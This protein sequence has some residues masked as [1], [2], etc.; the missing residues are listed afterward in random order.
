MTN[1]EMKEITDRLDK[2]TYKLGQIQAKLNSIEAGH[3]EPKE[4]PRKPRLKDIH[5]EKGYYADFPTSEEDDPDFK[6]KF[7]KLVRGLDE[8]S[9]K[10]ITQIIQRL[11]ILKESTDDFLPEFSDD[12]MRRLEFVEN[13]FYPEILR[14]CEG[15]YSYNG[16]VLPVPTFEPSVFLDKCGLNEISAPEEIVHRDIIDAGAFVGDSSLLLSRLT[17]ENV[18]AFEPTAKNYEN[19]LKTIEMNKLKNVVPCKYALGSEKGTID[20]TNAIVSSSNAFVENSRMPYTA[21]EKVDV[22]TLDEFVEEHNLDV[23]LIKTDVEGAE[24]MLLKGAMKT[25]RRQRPTLLISIYHNASDFFGIK[26][27]LEK[28]NVGYKFKI[29]RPVIGTVLMETMLIAESFGYYN[30]F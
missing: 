10:Q 3:A 11:R 12:E 22:I 15:C 2:L 6:R 20:M 16:Y 25:I 14:V 21:T 9:C 30:E 17:S 8:V 26:P 13:H 4:P 5:A 1:D 29:H 19:L 28:L 27:K 18:Y 24:Q 7:I 23:G